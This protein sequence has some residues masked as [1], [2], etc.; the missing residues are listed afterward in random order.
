MA[1]LPL[2]QKPCSRLRREQVIRPDNPASPGCCLATTL[3]KCFA[4]PKAASAV[5]GQFSHYIDEKQ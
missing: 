4:F 5:A 2:S 1:E 3:E